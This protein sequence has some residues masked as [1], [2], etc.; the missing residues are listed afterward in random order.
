[1]RARYIPAV[2]LLTALLAGSI[3]LYK[4]ESN[5]VKF[6]LI[7]EGEVVGH[8]AGS[9]SNLT[10]NGKTKTTSTQAIV[11]YK[12]NGVS[13]K[14]YGR[15]FG[16]PKWVVGQNVTVYYDPEKPKLARINRF[17]EMY[18]HTLLCLVFLFGGLFTAMFNYAVYK[19][20]GKVLS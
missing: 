4:L 1:M 14:V 8:G 11:E 18:L 2:I 6:M 20:T 10:V 17:D 16:Y 3:Y 9:T 13:Y 12:V 15:S 19:T 5:Y 7:V